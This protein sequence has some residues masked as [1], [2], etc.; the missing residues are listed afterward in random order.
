[1][2]GILLHLGCVTWGVFFEDRRPPSHAH[3]A[4]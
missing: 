4:R 1:L 3:A 2:D